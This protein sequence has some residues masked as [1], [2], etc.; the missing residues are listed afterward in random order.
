MNRLER[1]LPV[2]VTVVGLL[3]IGSSLRSAPAIQD[4]STHGLKRVFWPREASSNPRDKMRLAEFGRLPVLDNGRIKPLDTYARNH[5]MAANRREEWLDDKEDAQP[6]VRWFLNLA[7]G[8]LANHAAEMVIE[9]EDVV[10]WLKLPQDPRRPRV[11][12][13][14]DEILRAAEDLK[15]KVEALEAKAAK[16]AGL[17]RKVLD[18]VQDARKR[19]A[20]SRAL[21][22]SLGKADDP[23]RMRVFRI[24]FD[25]VL[26]L[27]KLERREGLRYS[28]EEIS[29]RV[30]LILKRADEAQHRAE[31][32]D[33]NKPVDTTDR[34]A[35]D[36]AEQLRFYIVM[37]RLEGLTM[38]PDEEFSPTGWKTLGQTLRMSGP[39]GKPAE[40]LIRIVA[41]YALGEADAFNE[42]VAAYG[43]LVK[44]NL[45]TEASKARQEAWFNHA[46]PFYRSAALY[47]LAFAL[48]V[49][50]WVAAP[51]A[52]FRSATALM[53]LVLVLHTF[54]LIYRMWLTGRPPV[55]NLYGSAV[56]IGW[57]CT[58]TCLLLDWL[59]YRNGIATAVGALLGFGTMVIAQF[60]GGSG[61]TM[62][63]LEAV[64]DTNFWLATHVTIVTLGYTATFVAGFLATAFLYR[65][66]AGTVLAFFRNRGN[67]EWSSAFVF[68]MALAGVLAVPAVLAVGILWSLLY[69]AT[70][71]APN[72]NPWAYPLGAAVILFA[73]AFGIVVAL[74]YF[75]PA[76][77]EAPGA[78]PGSAQWMEPLELDVASSKSM[79]NVVYGVVC[80]A[81][82]LSFIG[83]V[84]GGIWADQSWGRFWGWD[85]K[86]NGAIL[87]VI[88][89]ALILHARW[90]GMIR[91]RG[92]VMLALAGN[93]TTMWS[94]FGTNQLEIGLHSYGFS[95][96]LATMCRWFWVSQL[97]LMAL[98]A[99]PLKYWKSYAARPEAKAAKGAPRPKAAAGDPRIAPA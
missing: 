28:V 6:A 43:E 54:A 12:F 51:R 8:G 84:L 42:E 89:N 5:L 22:K 79:S 57:G 44:A 32:K 92:L 19:A 75:S 85:P 97:A 16:L 3:Y 4:P 55:V 40:H 63:V 62:A 34:R 10:E 76:P 66:L 61:D 53:A 20:R 46:A 81:V 14:A 18:T 71:D 95:S 23:E 93:M 31:E 15:G 58:V 39:K 38:V 36:L 60:L 80:F 98:A 94:W 27:L 82:L 24:D 88:I 90:G 67:P 70:G 78:I 21:V 26:H 9:D 50:S 91:E 7:A 68:S 2:A 33:P 69:M 87:V 49:L 56:F 17:E 29:P 35:M 77:D 37:S 86:E 41:A 73:V 64:L 1:W 99:L 13:R 11:V 96:A 25:Q 52:L 83:T 74:R 48:A 30:G 72:A 47:V 65:M 59:I 45:P